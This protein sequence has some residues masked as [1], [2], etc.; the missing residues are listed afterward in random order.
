MNIRC[1]RGLTLI[2]T[3][4][5]IAIFTSA[6]MALTTSVLVFYRTS[7]SAIQEA[8]ATASAQHGVDLLVRTIREASY[9]SNGAY[10]II[11]I[12]PND[13]QFYSDIDSDSLVEQV[14]Y[15]VSGTTLYEGV[16]NPTGDP[17][18]YA[19]PGVT[20]N[21]SLYVQNVAQAT[22]TFTYFDKNGV[23]ITD[24]TRIGD[25]RFVTVN[26]LVDVDPNRSPTIITLRSS[27]ALRNL[28]GK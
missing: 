2:E 3:V 14:H 26:L 12:A 19:N 6:M 16:I 28:V 22:S 24:F 7:N 21:T 5:W 25:V 9:S 4:V 1:T 8:T 13:I 23:Q 18:S 27:A 11:S 15:Y 20:S 17:P 10:P